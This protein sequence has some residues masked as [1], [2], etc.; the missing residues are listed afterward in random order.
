M[1]SNMLTSLLWALGARGVDL[2]GF[3]F[4]QLCAIHPLDAAIP[5]GEMPGRC[6]WMS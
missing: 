5:H 2:Q 3:A 1:R 4:T 6:R